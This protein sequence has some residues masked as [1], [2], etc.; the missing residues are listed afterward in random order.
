MK[1]SVTLSL[2]FAFIS[3][4]LMGQNHRCVDPVLLAG[5]ELRYKVQWGF[6]RLGTIIIRTLPDTA[7]ADGASY[8]VTMDLESNPDLRV[9][10]VAEYNESVVDAATHM[11]K[12]F[13]A[14]HYK[15]DHFVLIRAGYDT[16]RHLATWSE[17]SG[18]KMLKNDTLADVQPYV[19]GPSLF[20]F[21]R[22]LAERRGA[23]RV[24]TMVNGTIATT[25]INFT[26]AVEALD[27]EAIGRP[28]RVRKYVGTAEWTGGTTVGLSGDFT[29]WISDDDAAI[30]VRAEMKVIVG[31]IQV[32]LEA[33]K[34]PGWI[35]PT[36][37]ITSSR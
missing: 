31:S 6:L 4:P 11:S 1:N 25:L 33:W 12:R 28:V 18:G 37:M 29:G 22:Y 32:E 9:V 8:R 24:P 20:A 35:P 27:I 14:W 30:P 17:S 13:R 19:E 21:T 15:D 3:V 16:L 26:T 23:S 36:S 10:R 2:L 34:R 5:E 7:D